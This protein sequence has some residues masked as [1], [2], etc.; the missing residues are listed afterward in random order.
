MPRHEAERL[1]ALAVGLPRHRTMTR[2]RVSGSVLAKYRELVARR[3][4]GEP[5]QYIEGLVP[6]GPVDIAVDRRV[7]IPRVETEQLYALVAG[8]GPARVVVDMCTGSGCLGIAL[9]A[10]H[11]GTDLHLT[12]VS[13]DAL[14]VAEANADRNGVVASTWRGDCFDALPVSLRGHIDCFVANPPYVPEHQLA[15][16]EPQVRDHE[17]ATALIA[18]SDGL[19]VIRR[20][21]AELQAWLAPGGSFAV[22]IGHDQGAD[23]AALFAHVGGSVVADTFGRDRFV[24]G[25]IPR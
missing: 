17:P 25:R 21:A 5:L 13:S 24:V 18:G 23:V 6:F 12:D 10:T 1:L 2:D 15:E 22:E 20:I 16:L 8:W 19:E 11:P 4:S 3:R 9:A 7:L 14:D